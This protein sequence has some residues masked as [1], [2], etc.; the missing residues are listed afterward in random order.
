M[1]ISCSKGAPDC[2][3][4]VQYLKDVIQVLNS[5]F[6]QGKVTDAAWGQWIES[7]LLRLKHE[8]NW[9]RLVRLTK[10]W[11]G[12]VSVGKHFQVSMFL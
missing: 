1:E 3:C 7:E 11:V 10:Y 12:P 2:K 9:R 8:L 4:L 6:L 5:K